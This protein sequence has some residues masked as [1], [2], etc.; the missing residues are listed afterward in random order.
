ML[1]YAA[2]ALNNRQEKTVIVLCFNAFLF[3]LLKYILKRKEA[4]EKLKIKKTKQTN[5]HN[6]SIR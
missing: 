1:N 6:I 5:K 4:R 3:R 2:L